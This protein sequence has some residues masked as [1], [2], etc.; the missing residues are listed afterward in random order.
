LCETTFGFFF[1]GVT[2]FGGVAGAVAVTGAEALA[3]TG[4]PDSGEPVATATFVKLAV[5]A[6]LVH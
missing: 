3:V 1:A 6:G 5:T 4:G 2:F